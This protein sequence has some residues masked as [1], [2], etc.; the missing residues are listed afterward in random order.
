MISKSN[1]QKLKEV[2][3]RLDGKEI[4]YDFV[5]GDKARIRSPWKYSGSTTNDYR[6]PRPK[7]GDIVTIVDSSFRTQDGGFPEWDTVWIDHPSGTY[8]TFRESLAKL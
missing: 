7:P 1:D 2:E 4:L 3:T 6:L 5:K 8:A